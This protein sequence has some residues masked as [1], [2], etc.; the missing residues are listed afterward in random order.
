[1]TDLFEMTLMFT[2]FILQYLNKL[3]E[4]EVGDLTSPQAFQVSVKDGKDGV[5]LGNIGRT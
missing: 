5:M 2:T 4:G 1:M 3:V